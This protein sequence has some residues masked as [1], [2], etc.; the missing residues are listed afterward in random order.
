MI[1]I[2]LIKKGS[3]RFPFVIPLGS[4]SFKIGSKNQFVTLK[5]TKLV[6]D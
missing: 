2:N 4:C 1:E 5:I 3:F 6:T